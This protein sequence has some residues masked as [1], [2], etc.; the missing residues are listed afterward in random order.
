M[1][2]AKQVFNRLNIGRLLGTKRARRMTDLEGQIAALSRSMAVV[3]F[4]LDGTILAANENFCA[5]LG[6]RPDEVVG[7]HHRM[8]VTEH[9][10]QS[11]EYRAFWARLGRGEYDAGQYRRQRKDGTD[12]W[13]QATYNPIYDEQGR[14]FKVVKFATD[15]TEQR[16]RTA[17]YEGQIAAIDKAQAVIEFDLDGTILSANENFCAALGYSAEDVVG[18][19]HRIFVD[20]DYANSAEY[21][22]FW[23]RLGRGDYDAGQYMRRRK[24]GTEI[25]IQATYNP[26]YDASGKPFKVVKFATDITEQRLRNADYEGQ[27]AAIGKAQAVIE[28]NLDG[29]ILSANENFCAA[30]G[31]SAEEVIGKHHRIFVEGAYA[32]STEYREFWQRLGRGEYDAGQYVRRCKDGSD[33]WIQATYNPIFDANGRPFKV[34]KFATDITAERMRNADYEGQI[35]AISKAQAVI[36][37]ELDGTIISANENFCSTIGYTLAEIQGRHHKMFVDPTE[38]ASPDYATFW[39][40]LGRGEYDAGQYRRIRKDGTD[41]W[42]QASYNPIFDAAGRPFKV[43]KYATDITAQM[44]AREMRKTVEQTRNVITAAQQGDLTQRVSED[45][46]EGDLLELV[47]GINGVLTTFSG[48]IFSMKQSLSSINDA[49]REIAAGSQDLSRRTESQVARLEATASSMNALSSTVRENAENAKQANELA[50][51]ASDV[52]R[53]GGDVVAQ[54]VSNM[55]DITESSRQIEDIISVMEGIAFQ[56]NILALNAAVEAARAGE[57]GRG[58][59]VVASEVRSLAQRSATAAK[60]VKTLIGDSVR[61]IEDGSKNVSTA[62]STMNEIVDSVRRVTEIMA[63]ISQA[64]ASQSAD[65]EKAKQAVAQMDTAA[66][67]DAALVEESS[68]ATHVLEEQVTSLARTVRHYQVADGPQA[69]ELPDLQDYRPQKP[70][71][72][73][74]SRLLN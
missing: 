72:H 52:A 17:D 71:L 69:D 50:I 55:S 60:E 20:A 40:K 58:F 73:S 41:L 74:G 39:K 1:S 18:K 14:P 53:R 51:G 29:T 38:A 32:A 57:Q 54:V 30:L 15:I 34:V 4:N 3:E 24:D 44:K 23:K 49:S 56:T 45:G 5:V 31:Y 62:G 9:Y 67:E 11:D 43:V 2:V 63:N 8:F 37:F 61:R 65:I 68:A 42:I 48:V 19:H 70:G 13:I 27:I 35:A 47:Q 33:I 25:W 12:I 21:R 36:E 7:R 46:L 16:L 22:E 28:F 6:Y 64:S 59:A 26:I 66:Q 10:A